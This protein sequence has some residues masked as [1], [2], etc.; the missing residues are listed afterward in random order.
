M[1]AVRGGGAGGL[2]SSGAGQDGTRSPM[3]T[4][5]IVPRDFLRPGEEMQPPTIFG[6]VT[7]P[8]RALACWLEILGPTAHTNLTRDS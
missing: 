2:G 3:L 6:Y 7:A 8:A 4:L 1:R 5:Q